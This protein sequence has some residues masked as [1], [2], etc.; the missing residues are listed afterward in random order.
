MFLQQTVVNN[1]TFWTVVKWT[2]KANLM[3]DLPVS[4]FT[5]SSPAKAPTVLELNVTTTCIAS[6]GSRTPLEGSTEN[7][8]K[9][10]EDLVEDSH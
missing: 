1:E 10:K 6:L 7:G 5:L 8:L 2:G 3:L 9:W 4:Y